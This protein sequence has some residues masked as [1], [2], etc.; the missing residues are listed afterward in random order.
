MASDAGGKIY[1]PSYK[2]AKQDTRPQKGLWAPGNY[3]NVCLDCSKQFIGDKRARVCADCAYKDPQEVP[4]ICP[5]NLF[6][7]DVINA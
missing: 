2:N 4:V 1:S 7:V 3:L 5:I 6:D